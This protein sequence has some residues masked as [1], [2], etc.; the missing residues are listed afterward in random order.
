MIVAETNFLSGV[1]FCGGGFYLTIHSAFKTPEIIYP[2]IG[3][4]KTVYI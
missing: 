1:I 2:L 3:N 4:V